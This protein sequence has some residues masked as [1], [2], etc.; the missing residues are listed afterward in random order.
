MIRQ[1]ADLRRVGPAECRT[2]ARLPVEAWL[3][4]E[5]RLA[6]LGGGVLALCRPQGWPVALDLPTRTPAAFQRRE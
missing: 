5:A 2:G 6:S 1:E 3:A 4:G